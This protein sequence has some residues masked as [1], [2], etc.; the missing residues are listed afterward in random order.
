M[1]NES[2][3]QIG[4]DYFFLEVKWDLINFEIE[5]EFFCRTFWTCSKPDE[6]RGTPHSSGRFRTKVRPTGRIPPP[7]A[8]TLR[9]SLQPQVGAMCVDGGGDGGGSE[10][11]RAAGV[12]A[13]RMRRAVR[14]VLRRQ[15]HH[16]FTSR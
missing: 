13:G 11:P 5:F 3:N 8:Q 12:C 6:I 16:A 15:P 2:K 4:L 1:Q 9:P 10:P 14:C 7:S